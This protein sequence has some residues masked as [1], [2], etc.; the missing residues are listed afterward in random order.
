MLSEHE[1]NY[2]KDKIKEVEEHYN[3]ILGEKKSL[4]V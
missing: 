2:L 1:K 3:K 4:E